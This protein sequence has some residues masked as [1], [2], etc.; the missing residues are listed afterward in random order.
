MCAAR[1]I[2]YA[3]SITILSW[4]LVRHF[5]NQGICDMDAAKRERR[6]II[7]TTL[8]VLTVTFT[9]YFVINHILLQLIGEE[10]GL[11]WADDAF[12]R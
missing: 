1:W 12:W 6:K 11:P 10:L 8:I 3:I 5:R 9:I 7:N 2:L 4:G